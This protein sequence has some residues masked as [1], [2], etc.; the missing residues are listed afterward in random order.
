MRNGFAGMG[1]IVDDE[2]VAVFVEAEL[3]GDV[4]G[5]E[6]KMSEDSVVFGGGFVD[7]W[8]GFARDDEDVTRGGGT[9]VAKSEHLIIF[10]NDVSGDFAI[11]DF[12]KERF[13]HGGRILF[14]TAI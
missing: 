8:N 11:G 10:V 7:A 12:L 14:G 9:N 1:A 6:K 5:F 13:A 2:T 3:A 4:G